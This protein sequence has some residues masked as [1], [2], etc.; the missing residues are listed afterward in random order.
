MAGEC[1]YSVVGNA[2]R[3]I[4]ILAT[5]GYSKLLY[6]S[7]TLNFYGSQETLSTHLKLSVA[8]TLGKASDKDYSEF[9]SEKMV[10]LILKRQPL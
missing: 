4:Q 5:A 3:V 9:Q 2:S 6:D 8:K 10:I 1:N 7:N